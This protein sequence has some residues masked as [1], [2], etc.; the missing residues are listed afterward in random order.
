MPTWCLFACQKWTPF[1]TSFLRYCK[2]IANLLLW[3][4]WEC[5]IMPVNNDSI[6]LKETLV[7]KVLKSTCRK[8]W[9]L[10]ACKKSTSSNFFFD[11]VKTLQ[12]C[13]FGNFGNAWAS[14]LKSFHQFVARFNV[15]LQAKNQLH[16]PFFSGDIAKICKLL[17]LGTLYM[18]SYTPNMIV[19]TCRRL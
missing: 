12:T 16:S 11:I 8:L 17:V 15:Y 7:P 14:L 2:N 3:V 1:L 5:L 19:S 4:L 18:P 9:C 10:S 6:T 13:Y